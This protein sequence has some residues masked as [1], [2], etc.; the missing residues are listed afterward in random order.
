VLPV[1]VVATTLPVTLPVK[2]PV[3]VVAATASKLVVPFVSTGAGE[4]AFPKPTEITTAT[5][6]ARAN[7]AIVFKA[8]LLLRTKS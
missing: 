1:T 8:F 2:A 5:R 7:L 6:T 4:V 3:K